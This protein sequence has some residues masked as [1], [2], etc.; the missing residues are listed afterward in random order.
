MQRLECCVSCFAWN[1]TV[2]GQLSLAVV[3]QMCGATG[4]ADKRPRTFVALQCATTSIVINGSLSHSTIC[5]A[6]NIF[7]ESVDV[8]I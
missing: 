6:T 5:G 3:S 2:G 7:V 1:G 8:E 4:G